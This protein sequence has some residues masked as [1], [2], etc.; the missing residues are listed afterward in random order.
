MTLC[1]TGY[2]CATVP[3]ARRPKG[4]WVPFFNVVGVIAGPPIM[5]VYLG[6]AEAARDLALQKV[7]KKRDD[8]EVWYLVGEMENALVTAQMAVREA[9]DI[10]PDCL[11][12][13][14]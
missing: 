10:C 1:W 8:P 9:I 12:M 2:S 4:V 6:V 3:P 5:S 14:D 13:P 7:A 11:F